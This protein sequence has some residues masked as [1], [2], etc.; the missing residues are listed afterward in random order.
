MVA[1]RTAQAPSGPFDIRL[2]HGEISG[3]GQRRTCPLQ[4]EPEPIFD[5]K[6]SLRKPVGKRWGVSGWTA[7]PPVP[8]KSVA[9]QPE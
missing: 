4:V 7:G 6:R 5:P 8:T 1:D 3:S 2:G 9:P